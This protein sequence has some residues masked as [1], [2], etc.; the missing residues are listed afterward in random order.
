MTQA[1]R[2]QLQALD[3]AER[4]ACADLLRA[5]SMGR[6]HCPRAAGLC[7][8]LAAHPL[9]S[10]RERRPLFVAWAL[11]AVKAQAQGKEWARAYNCWMPLVAD[12]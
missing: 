1:I 3:S 5:R 4:G 8:R 9:A 7:S 12:A 6:R 2:T 11:A 10:D